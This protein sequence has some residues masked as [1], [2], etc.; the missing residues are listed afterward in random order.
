M[1]FQFM[2]HP[3]LVNHPHADLILNAEKSTLTPSAHVSMNISACL[4]I[5]DLNV[6]SV[7][8]AVKTRLASN[9]NVLTPVLVHVVRMQGAKS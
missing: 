8:N 3:T 4:P 1:C 2:S 7:P 6:Q 5:V 9:K